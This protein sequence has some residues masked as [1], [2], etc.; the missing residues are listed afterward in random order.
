MQEDNEL[1]KHTFITTADNTIDFPY[2]QPIS[3]VNH[4]QLDLLK[5]HPNVGGVHHLRSGLHDP[6]KEPS[7]PAAS[8]TPHHLSRSSH[9]ED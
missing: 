4:R 2:I 9:H 8:R 5:C 6:P 1:L 7:P 3:Q